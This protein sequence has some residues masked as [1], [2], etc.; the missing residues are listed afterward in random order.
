MM[1]ISFKKQRWEGEGIKLKKKKKSCKLQQ[2]FPGSLQTAE[3]M[4]SFPLSHSHL[5]VGL[6]KMFPLSLN[7]GILS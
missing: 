4:Y 3:G 7:K 2:I 1:L 5:Q 6:F